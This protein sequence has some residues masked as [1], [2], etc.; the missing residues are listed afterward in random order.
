MTGIRA[1]VWPIA[2]MVL[3]G[4][5]WAK[6]LAG[7]G[8]EDSPQRAEFDERK[9]DSE[10]AELRKQPLRPPA[11][12]DSLDR[13]RAVM[14]RSLA[15]LDSVVC[16]IEKS[17]ARKEKGRRRYFHGQVEIQRGSGGRVSLTRKGNTDEYVANDRVIWSI[18]H[19]KKQAQFIPASTP[20]VGQYVREALNFNIFLALDEDTLRLRGSQT[21]EG[22]DCWLVDGKSPRSLARTGVPV[23]KVRVW[24]AKSDGL[25]RMIHIPDDEDDQLIILRNI[26]TNLRIDS[27]RFQW[28]PPKGMKTKNIFGF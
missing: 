15:S 18:D 27:E 4:S 14:Q 10:I 3:L 16:E 9:R 19:N 12:G 1:S 26:K 8:A 22:E 7:A 13:V 23:S 2:I 6:P 24:I 28:S 11:D 25:P 20:V 21:I 17:K 5:L